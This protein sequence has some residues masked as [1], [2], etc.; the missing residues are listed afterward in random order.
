M[1]VGVVGRVDL[2]WLGGAQGLR[3]QVDEHQ[4]RMGH[5]GAY[6]IYANIAPVSLAHWLGSECECCCGTKIV[7]SRACTH[8]SGSGH[9]PIQGDVTE[10]E[11]VK[12]MV[13]ELERIFRAHSARAGAKMRRAA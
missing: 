6:A 11:R 2:D 5:Q 9:E 3:P 12:G 1:L 13:S 7:E 10:V 4:A 8:C